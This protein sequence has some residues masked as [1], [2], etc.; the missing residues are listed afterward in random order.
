MEASTDWDH[1][2]FIADGKK[3]SDFTPK[4]WRVNHEWRQ[5]YQASRA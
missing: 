5:D 4:G 1:L 3:F 2:A